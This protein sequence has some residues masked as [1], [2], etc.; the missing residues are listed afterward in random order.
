MFTDSDPN[1]KREADR[2]LAG[3]QKSIE[4]WTI[5][6]QIL[7]QEPSSL[8]EYVSF[9]A[10]QTLRSKMR[11]SFH[12]L[13]DHSLE[14]LRSSIMSHILRRKT[15]PKHI[16]TQLAMALV[17]LAIQMESWSG[18]VEFLV[19]TLNADQSGSV[20]LLKV[21]KILPE[22]ATD[23]HFPVKSER[24]DRVI[25]EIEQAAQGVLS[26]LG[27]LLAA[28]SAPRNVATQE[29]VFECLSSWIRYA[30]IPPGEKEH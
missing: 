5:A 3:F 10:A 24:R 27:Q 21:L 29:M 8:P 20:C 11:S 25:H 18:I 30:R 28:A 14:S 22:D 4:A 2:W 15:G 17:A 19:S 12:E 16:L 6:D 9:F 1:R 23:P 26:I 13:P 7:M